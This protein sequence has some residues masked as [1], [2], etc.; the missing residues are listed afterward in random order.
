MTIKAAIDAARK[1]N[2]G[3]IIIALPV[4]PL[5]TAR[6]LKAL[7]D[8]TI[9]LEIPE[10]FQSVGQLYENFRQVETEEVRKIL[11]EACCDREVL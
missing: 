8:E 1:Q 7:A 2:P 11:L 6:E 3:K 10:H 5:E 9:I 4:A